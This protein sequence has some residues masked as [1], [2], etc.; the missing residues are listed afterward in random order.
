MIAKLTG[1]LESSGEGEAVIDVGGVGYL[2]QASRATLEALGPPGSSVAVVTEMRVREEQWVLY[3]FASPAERAWFRLLTTLQGVGPKAALAVL[4]VLPPDRLALAIASG[5][6]SAITR[7]DGV[8]PKLAARI[9]AELKD[10]VGSLAMP[11]PVPAPGASRGAA[12][13]GGAPLS[14]APSNAAA[15]GAAATGEAVFGDAVSA[16]VNL[17]YASSEAF[18]AVT[19]VRTQA[20]EAALGEIIRRALRELSAHG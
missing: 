15:A 11:V 18:L 2:I 17:G 16:L 3:G 13:P 12:S 1:R 20:P 10:K 14:A 9:V 5:D 6:K 19:A 4:S 7:A 8:G